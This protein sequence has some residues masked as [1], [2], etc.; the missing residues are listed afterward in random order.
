[1][2]QIGFI[3]LGMM[4]GPM[5]RRLAA[6]GMQLA[7]YDIERERMSDLVGDTGARGCATPAEV[8]AFSDVVITM[9][10]T[11]AT[12]A[13]VVLGDGDAAGVIAGMNEAG[14]IVDM[15]SVAPEETRALGA[16][17][18]G[19]GVR[20]VDAPVSGGVA[21][22]VAGT[23]TIIAGGER[24]DIDSCGEIF[25]AIGGR[26]IHTGPLGTGHA[27]KAINNAVS[28]A[29]LIAASEALIVGQRAGVDPAVMLEVLNTSSG[30]NHATRNKIDQFVFSRTFASGF[31]LSLMAKDLDIAQGLA[32]RYQVESDL[33]SRSSGLVAAAYRALGN[34]ADHT[35]IVQWLEERNG[36]VLSPNGRRAS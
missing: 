25:A 30:S 1:M 23:L 33:L 24:K 13:K 16:R 12:V 15:S 29:G 3:G 35:A 8:A 20:M 9:L 6:A 28:A 7:V 34:G 32:E 27:A 11:G 5:A 21:G 10:P 19:E 31:A 22:A 2:R 18:A 36:T 26:T 4:G 17:I 14:L